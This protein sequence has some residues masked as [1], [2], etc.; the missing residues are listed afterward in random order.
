VHWRYFFKKNRDAPLAQLGIGACR[1]KNFENGKVSPPQLVGK[2]TAG[3]IL[4][5]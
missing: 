5:A 1:M 3:G 4:T 2:N